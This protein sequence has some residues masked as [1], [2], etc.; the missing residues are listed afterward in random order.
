[1]GDVASLSIVATDQSPLVRAEAA[2]GLACA[3]AEGVGDLRVTA[4]LRRLIA[5]RGRATG[6]AVAQ[7]IAEAADAAALLELRGL[8]A[9][10]PSAEVRR[11]VGGSDDADDE[12][13][14][15]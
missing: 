9:D 10:H 5:D 6:I 2:Y 12:D 15:G 11:L 7:V 8:L 1:M 4:T 3:A 13:G 14:E